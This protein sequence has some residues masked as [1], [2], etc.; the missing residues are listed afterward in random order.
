VAHVACIGD[1]KSYKIIVRKREWKSQLGKLGINGRILSKWILN[2]QDVRLNPSGSEYD[3]VVG[4]CDHN[5]EPS[6][7]IKG[8]EFIASGT[9]E[10]M[11]KR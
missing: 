7:S 10:K 2:E 8:R 6:G 1:E 3:S 4:F 5:N 9:P 11:W